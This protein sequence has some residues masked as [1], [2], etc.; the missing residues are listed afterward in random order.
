MEGQCEPDGVTHPCKAAN[1]RRRAWARSRDSWQVSETQDTEVEGHPFPESKQEKP[2]SSE[3]PEPNK[4]TSWLKECRYGDIRWLSCETFLLAQFSKWR[5]RSLWGCV[6]QLDGELAKIV[7]V[8]APVPPFLSNR[9]ER[10]GEKR[11]GWDGT[12]RSL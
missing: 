5:L 9:K 3:E 4:I 7:A 11:Q 10:R 6:S 8:V 12:F 1:A 2:L